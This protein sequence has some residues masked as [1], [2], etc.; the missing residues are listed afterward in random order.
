MKTTLCILVIGL[1]LSVPSVSGPLDETRYCGSPVR[2]ADGSI[3][4]SSTVLVKFK[5]IHPC[6]STL[7]TSGSCPGWS[8]N[9]TIPLACGGC[10]SVSNLQWLPNDIKTCTGPHCVD[11]FE[12]KINAAT[13]P[14]LDTDSCKNI[15]VL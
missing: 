13:P 5:T 8:M 6:P 3:K 9:H 1:L 11:R 2:N 12:R 4:R 10:D 7:L 14:Y 15:I